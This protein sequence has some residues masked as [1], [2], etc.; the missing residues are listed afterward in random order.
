MEKTAECRSE[1]QEPRQPVSRISLRTPLAAVRRA[2]RSGALF[3]ALLMLVP[4]FAGLSML[5]AHGPAAVHTGINLEPSLA[6]R[7]PVFTASPLAF[8]QQIIGNVTDQ[9]P[10][11]VAY[12]SQSGNLYTADYTAN[13]VSVINGA[14]GQVTQ[15]IS[16][17]AYISDPTNVLYD[18]MN[19]DIYVSG[20]SPNLAHD[21]VTIIS[22]ASNTVIG[23]VDLLNQ[24]QSWGMTLDT[25][26]G[27]IY[28]TDSQ[29]YNVSVI[30]GATNTFVT[31]IRV[32]G[33]PEAAAYDSANNEVYV[34]NHS[35]TIIIDPTTETVVGGLIWGT[36]S[37]NYHVTQFVTFD[38]KNGY[39]Y[40]TSSGYDSGNPNN[41][42]YSDVLV[43]NG[44]N[45][46]FVTEIVLGNQ[47]DPLGLT[48]DPTDGEI[49]VANSG[50][51][52]VTVINGST[53]QIDALVSLD[54][55]LGGQPTD[56]AYDASNQN[57]YVANWIDDSVG[58]I[59]T[60]P[61]CASGAQLNSLT[62]NPPTAS[63]QVGTT[64]SLSATPTCSGGSCSNT[65]TYAWTLNNTLGQLSSS[66]GQSVTFTASSAGLT[67]LTV[68]A[69]L[70][71]S[72]AQATA[73]LTLTTSAV[74]G[75]VSVSIT[76]SSLSVVPNGTQT[77]GASAQCSSGSCP[78]GGVSFVWSLNNTLGHLS[79]STGQSVT[80]TAG[81]HDGVVTL[82][83][84]ATLSGTTPKSNH[85]VIT[86]GSSGGGGSGGGSSNGWLLWVLV[87]GIAGVA[88]V[89]VVLVYLLKMRKPRAPFQPFAPAPPPGSY[90]PPPSTAPPPP[91]PA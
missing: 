6:Q 18:P 54:N 79:S 36:S 65:I 3:L 71:A 14:T 60:H 1:G 87:G 78:S 41:V 73:N 37:F 16:V 23:T 63:V 34:T 21:N 89:A 43:I 11:D 77:F 19:G 5:P 72:H 2:P 13:N 67:A 32:I 24:S 44:A 48:F 56:V 29:S 91:P 69:T 53:N 74:P 17:L 38:P 8:T 25:T 84:T 27:F 31:N 55:P 64:L 88:V 26:N 33:F 52:N 22:T 47:T 83:V 51:D 7:S 59:C 70:G 49:Y 76:P 46:S 15:N 9:T 35:G 80:F 4:A 28:V 82:T 12:D 58:I 57:I 10:Y 39:L 66:S 45:N 75:V 30:D 86:I 85:A 50:Q 90:P 40:V 68:T 81:P 62:V 61:A 20:T 42:Y